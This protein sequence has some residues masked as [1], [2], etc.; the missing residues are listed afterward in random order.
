MALPTVPGMLNVFRPLRD[1]EEAVETFLELESGVLQGSLGPIDE[2]SEGSDTKEIGLG[3]QLL[4]S[5][6]Y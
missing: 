6:G 3:L 2:T 4:K 1:R 5:D